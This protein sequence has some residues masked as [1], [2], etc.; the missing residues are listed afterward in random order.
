MKQKVIACLFCALAAV[1][2]QSTAGAERAGS[3]GNVIL[4]FGVYTQ[5]YGLEKALADY[6]VRVSNAH[7]KGVEYFPAPEELTATK[8][9]IL[10]DVGG[11]EFSEEQVQQLA[12]YVEHGGHVFV[13]G[14]PF[15]LGLGRLHE[16]GLAA[17]LPVSLAPFDLKWEKKGAAF[18]RTG[19]HALAEGI[20]L[21]ARP[22][23]YWIHNVVPKE[24]AEI[25]LRAGKHPLLVSGK[26]GKGSVT[27]FTGTPMGVPASGDTPFWKW[28]Q[29]PKL[30]QRIA[31]QGETQ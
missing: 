16:C 1:V 20:D 11:G 12:S 6:D 22:K 26:Y 10:S 23:V 19:E 3:K 24:E 13:L 25:I 17:I 5:W 18:S 2:V 31:E 7:S 4:F 30:M 29:W 14:G 9:V 27:V 28:S 8:L 21:D 15:T